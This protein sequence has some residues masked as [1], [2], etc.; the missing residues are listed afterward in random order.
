MIDATQSIRA[1]NLGR[2][3]VGLSLKYRKM[4]E[5]AFS[6]F[7]GSCH[8]FNERISQEP[9]HLEAPLAWICGDLHLENFGSYKA[10]NRQ[11]YFDIND[12]DE[13]CLAPLSYELVRMLC[14]ITLGASEAGLSPEESDHLR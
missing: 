4:R 2:D 14:S 12:F 10:D 3:P 11:V 5:S 8:L 9:A 6:F 13:A 1:F 7:R